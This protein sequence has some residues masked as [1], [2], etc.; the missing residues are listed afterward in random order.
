MELV[1]Y[2]VRVAIDHARQNDLD[3]ELYCSTLIREL[4]KMT[5][6]PPSE[7]DPENYCFVDANLYAQH[8]GNC[9]PS[10]QCRRHRRPLARAPLFEGLSAVQMLEEPLT[11]ADFLAASKKGSG[12]YFG[13]ELRNSHADDAADMC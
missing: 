2:F 8:A 12:A 3:L 5:A 11:S 13:N 6:H 1:I 4:Q 7:S 10:L 9:G